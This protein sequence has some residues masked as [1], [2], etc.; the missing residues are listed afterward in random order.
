MVGRYMKYRQFVIALAMGLAGGAACGGGGDE[1]AEEIIT[2]DTLPEAARTKF[3]AWKAKPIKACAWEEAFPSLAEQYPPPSDG[4]AAPRPRVELARV[5]AENQGSPLLSDAQGELVMLGAPAADSLSATRAH[6]STRT[7]N[8]RTTSFKI[9][10]NLD[11][12]T[13]VVSL[14]GEEL[15]R[16]SLAAA[17]PVVLSLDAEALAPAGTD[18]LPMQD[19]L[20]GE[21]IARSDGGRLVRHALAALAPTARAQARLAARYELPAAVSA[22]LF[23][24]GAAA[25]PGLAR[26][27][28]PAGAT[29]FEPSSAAQLYGTRAQLQ[30]LYD[31]GA[32]TVELLFG[33]LPDA[34][35]ALRAELTS[36]AGGT[37]VKATKI[38]AA[39]AVPFDD[40]A[41]L[42]CFAQREAARHFESGQ[43]RSPA[44]AEQYLGCAFLAKD[45]FAA[46][47]A[48]PAGRAAVTAQAMR[49][50][51][52][53]YRGWDDAMIEVAQRA[54]GLGLDLSALGELGEV[55]GHWRALREGAASLPAATKAPIERAAIA[56][57]F[58]WHFNALSPSSLFVQDVAAAI[59]NAGDGFARSAER[60]LSDVALSL[61]PT[62][63]GT[64][65]V[66]CGQ[67]LVAARR[68]AVD[69]AVSAAALVP[70]SSAFVSGFSAE[71]LQACPSDAS[72][73]A[74]EASAPAVAAFLTADAKLDGGSATYPLAAADLVEHALEQRWSAATFAALPD[75]L[76]YAAIS[77]YT[78][79][80]LNQTRAQQ[81]GCVDSSFERLGAGAGGLLAPAVAAR[82]AELA[83]TLTAR[84]PALGG[85]AFFT[86]RFDLQDAYFEGLWLGCSDAGFSRARSKLLELLSALLAAPTF[87][88]RFAL[89][90]ELRT[91]EQATTCP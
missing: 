68:A 54:H 82:N 57:A 89:E 11:Q 9:S 44:F 63:A 64:R 90:E 35:L 60:M 5:L 61:S 71:L 69:R 1:G 26:L 81:A 43:V 86:A 41:M 73:A 42:A 4:G 29:P 21:P 32:A 37:G 27:V 84:W 34:R 16:A 18:L 39:P 65:A 88:S 20:D 30:P 87:D 56:L 49:T 85:A 52:N 80:G 38:S 62:G 24:L 77:K 8:G 83:R 47:A 72:V 14:G 79:C 50:G 6:E 2:F 10:S 78:F 55:L 45:G 19:A 15:Y 22:E 53:A 70:Y 67:A 75:V 25:R 51:G 23:P 46:L 58:R 76:D 66:R 31:G 3:E 13:C 74:L 33:G 28:T 12:G 40:A 17:V 7:V 36:S 48:S 59:G 91:L